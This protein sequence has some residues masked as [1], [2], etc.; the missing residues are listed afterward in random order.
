MLFS[1]V[2]KIRCRILM[3]FLFLFLLCAPS[4]AE[5]PLILVSPGPLIL[6]AVALAEDSSIGMELWKNQEEAIARLLSGEAAA[7][8]LPMTLGASAA[9]KAD[10]VLL[11]VFRERLFFLLSREPISLA[12]PEALKGSELLL[13]QGRGTVLDFLV[14]AVLQ[15]RGLDPEKDLRLV[16]APAPE[17]AMLFNQGK[18]ALAALPEP[19]ATTA[20]SAGGIRTDLQDVWS[21]GNARSSALPVAGV[22]ALRG[23]VE[24]APQDAARIVEAF[25]RAAAAFSEDPKRACERAARLLNI[26]TNALEKA[27]PHITIAF[28]SAVSA[29]EDVTALLSDFRK[30]VSTDVYDLPGPEF[31]HGG[32]LR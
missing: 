7:V 19:F 26:K 15:N 31:Y 1:I 22:F 8:V 3:A 5:R 2:P 20:L 24:G 18:H 25:S 6:P 23:Y 21:E 4:R 10:I 29:S 27:L 17:A 32:K 11:G 28:E 12:S 9:R 13:A 16:Y 30:A 14:R